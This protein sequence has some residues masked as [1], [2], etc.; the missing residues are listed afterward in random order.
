MS[1]ERCQRRRIRAS[2]ADI[3]PPAVASG[4]ISKAVE[5]N[6][7]E[8]LGDTERWSLYAGAV[9]SRPAS[10]RLTGEG[11]RSHG[12]WVGLGLVFDL[13]FLVC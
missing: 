8:P 4:S 6:V 10:F 12:S 3:S 13:M 7:S 9:P 1:Y 5:A 11:A 2:G